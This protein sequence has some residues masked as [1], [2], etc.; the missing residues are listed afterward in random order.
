MATITANPKN[1]FC[2]K[3]YSNNVND[4]IFMINW[5]IQADIMFVQLYYISKAKAIAECSVGM[6]PY[7][8]LQLFQKLCG[9][10]KRGSFGQMFQNSMTGG[11]IWC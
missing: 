6:G 1:A 4:R 8:C 10:K 7:I 11:S 9:C 3:T 5:Q 2:G